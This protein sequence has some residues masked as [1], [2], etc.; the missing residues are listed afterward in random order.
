MH[1]IV[2]LKPRPGE[3]YLK[4]VCI[5][6]FGMFPADGRR[7]TEA[8]AALLRNEFM[9]PGN[10]FRDVFRSEYVTYV[11]YAVM[12]NF[13]TMARLRD[14]PTA[15]SFRVN[16]DSAPS[17]S[18]Y[19]DVKVTVSLRNRANAVLHTLSSVEIACIAARKVVEL[20]SYRWRSVKK[21]MSPPAVLDTFD[22]EIGDACNYEGYFQSGL[23][24][25]SGDVLEFKCGDWAKFRE[26]TYP[27]EMLRVV[28]THNRAVVQLLTAS[29]DVWDG[30]HCSGNVERLSAWFRDCLIQWFGQREIRLLRSCFL[31]SSSLDYVLSDLRQARI[32]SG[33][34]PR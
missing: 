12:F 21:I 3:G 16:V 25:I 10:K 5:V 13:G 15:R 18:G 31:L 24:T 29:G 8:V 28:Y 14:W 20:M 23:V 30:H 34:N 11:D 9:L 2:K 6:W 7:I 17:W 32:S 22:N 33:P 19:G 1:E 4:G 26:R 27:V